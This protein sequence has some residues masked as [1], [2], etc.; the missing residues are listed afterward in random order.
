MKKAPWWA[1][2]SGVNSDM[3]RRDTVSRLV[4]WFTAA[5]PVPEVR[6]KLVVQELY[7]V[8]TCGADFAA[9]IRKQYD[10]FGGI[11]RDANIRAE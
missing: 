7:P 4:S 8:G 11:V 9:Y 2:T 1:D 10:Y 3:M 5:I 6:A